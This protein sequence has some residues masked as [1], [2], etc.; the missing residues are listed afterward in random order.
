MYPEVAVKKPIISGYWRADTQQHVH[1]K[2]LKNR[3]RSVSEYRWPILLLVEHIIDTEVQMQI[4]RGVD[5][6]RI[7]AGRSTAVHT[8]TVLDL[9]PDTG[10]QIYSCTYRFRSNEQQI[11][12]QIPLCRFT[13]EHTHTYP[14]LYPDT[15]G[16]I[17]R[18]TYIYSSRSVSG[19]RRPNS[20]MYIHIH[21]CISVSG[22]RPA[23]SQMKIHI[24][25]YISIRIPAS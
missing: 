15:G 8:Y 14:Y 25:I 22:Y 17:H 23:D 12:I 1:K 20:Q 9:Y 11:C 18:Y 5:C 7:P 6:V 21:I 4:R 10:G 13:D 3:S 24:H 16:Q 19:Y 2:M